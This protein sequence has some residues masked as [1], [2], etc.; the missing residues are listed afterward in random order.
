MNPTWLLVLV[1]LCV[2]L[3]VLIGGVCHDAELAD[4]WTDG[5][6]VRIREERDISLYQE[7]L[8]R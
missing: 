4:A 8:S 5:Y 6:N 1:L 3:G 7:R 2:I